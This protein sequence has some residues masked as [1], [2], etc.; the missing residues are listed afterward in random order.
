ME[1]PLCVLGIET[2]CDDTGLSIVIDQKI[3]SNIV[4][5]SA[6]LHVKTGGVVPEIAARCHEQNLFKAI[7]DLNFEI[8]DLSHI[9]YACNPG[10]AGCLHVGATFARSLSFLLDKPLLPINH[11]YAHIF[12]CL[13]DQDLNKLQLP[14]LGLVI[15]GG[16][17][18]IYLVKSFYELELIAETSDDAIGEVYDKIGRAMGFD[19][20]AGS[21]IDSLFNKELVKPHY[22]FKPSTKWTKFS[23][24]GL[25]SQCLNKIKQISANKTRIDWSELASNFQATIIDHYIDH[26]KNAIKKFASKM[27]LVG[28]GV[29]ANS[30]LSN[31]ISTLNLPFLIA[32]SKYTSDNGAMIGFYASLLINGDKN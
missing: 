4:I 27:L 29:S 13:I 22:F 21:K 25:K 20:P 17:T 30:Y 31:R 3:K 24:S 19:Y 2:T 11:L 23:Y 16:H 28:G 8:R 15:S 14:A 26:V 1:Q 10:L 18:A 5:S 32:D 7:R 12:S 6:N 9:A